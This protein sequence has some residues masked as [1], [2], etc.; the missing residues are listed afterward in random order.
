M[1]SEEFG[2]VERRPTTVDL[3]WF[4]DL[5]KNKQL[6]LDP[7]YQR[8]SV[9]TAGDRRYFL[10]TIFRNYPSP[11]IF[12]HKS[13]DDDG[14]VTY[15]VV[16]GKQRI[17][18]ILLFVANKIFLPHDFGDDRLSGKRWRQLDPSLRRIFWNYPIPIE[19]IDAVQGPIIKDVFA[20]LNKNSRKLTRQELRHARFDGWLIEF[21]EDEALNDTWR[22]FRIRTPA[23][24]KRMLDVQNLSELFEV[25]FRGEINGFDQ[26]GLDELYAELE[27]P[28][29]EDLLVSTE[30]VVEDFMHAKA[31]LMQMEAHNQAVSAFAQPFGHLYTLWALIVIDGLKS[32]TP[33]EFANAYVAFMKRVEDYELSAELVTDG[34]DVALVHETDLNMGDGPE[35]MFVENPSLVEVNLS[36]R[37]VAVYKMNSIGASTELPQRRLRLEALRL[38]LG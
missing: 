11:A 9:W 32:K 34:G 28:D 23:K 35:A 36:D 7:S 13:I 14:S 20:R 18:T 30:G 3:S 27:E 12:L 37:N 8:R 25:V 19:Q 5:E 17:T 31:L 1:S 29:S 6:D 24:E 4:L 16:D 33:A 2:R 38:G 15:H 26:D 22:T 10:D 21:I